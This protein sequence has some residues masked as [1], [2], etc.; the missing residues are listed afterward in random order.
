[1]NNKKTIKII[2]AGLS[3]LTAGINLAKAGYKVKIFEKNNV[4]GKR[5][6]NDYQGIENWFYKQD[7]L[8]H[9]QK[10]NIKVNF[11]YRP[12][13]VL[14]IIG[15][16]EKVY[17][18]QFDRN[19]FYLVKRG[20][21]KDTLDHAI[22][23]QAKKAGVEIIFNSPKDHR[24]F[25]DI[26]AQGYFPDEVTDV[27]A[28][29]YNFQTDTSDQCW[30][31]FDDKIAPDG[32]AYCLIANGKATLTICIFKNFQKAHG[33]LETAYKIFQQK[34]GFQSPK[35]KN[36]FSGVSN[37]FLMRTATFNGRLYVGES[38]G[39]IGAMGGFGMKYAFISGYLAA[40][41]II[42]NENYDKLWKKHL[43]SRLKAGF[44]N[45]WYY[46][47]LSEKTYKF[48]LKR[49]KKM[50]DPMAFLRKASGYSF[51]HRMCIPF[52]YISLRKKTQDRRKL[53]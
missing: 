33:Y 2:G 53:R 22:Y 6:H 47:I 26:V 48:V 21:D 28:V 38:A 27:I 9:I 19:A 49:M 17:N 24:E 8:E 16:Q 52:A 1:M 5:F 50:K 18:F 10:L 42:N 44:V 39:F 23:Q 46:K 13:R 35:E 25:G 51:V 4:V 11:P 20:T 41:S 36:E 32:Y 15:P 12:I 7:A 29:G 3:G 40:Q 37:S 34:I 30:A 43:L 31:I 45:R 14:N